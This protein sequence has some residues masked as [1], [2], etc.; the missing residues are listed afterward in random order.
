MKT[1]A[2]PRFRFHLSSLFICVTIACLAFALVGRFGVDG[3]M[4]RLQAALLIASV[5][6]PLIEFYYWWKQN[7]L[8][9]I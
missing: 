2:M 3:F 7:D 9:N 5:F 1:S 6:F 4:H 8:D